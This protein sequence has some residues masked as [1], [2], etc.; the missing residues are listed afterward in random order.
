MKKTMVFVG[1]I[2]F[3]VVLSGCQTNK[4]T[5][6][7]ADDADVATLNEDAVTTSFEAPPMPPDATQ[8]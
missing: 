6:G 2:C 5:T 4:T 3:A 7:T 8:P 1:I